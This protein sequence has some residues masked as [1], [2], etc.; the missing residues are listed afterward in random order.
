MLNSCGA[1]GPLVDALYSG[2]ER[3][4]KISCGKAQR[5][6]RSHFGGT[7]KG[8]LSSMTRTALKVSRGQN[9]VHHRACQ[10]RGYD[11]IFEQRCATGESGEVLV[12]ISGRAI[13]PHPARRRVRQIDR[14]EHDRVTVRR[15][16]ARTLATRECNASWTGQCEA[17]HGVVF[18]AVMCFLRERLARVS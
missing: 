9:T 11:S 8:T 7:A 13:R 3:G 5:R 17:L 14:H 18:H 10:R 6:Q 1:D 15:R 16:H 4:K 2:F 12:A